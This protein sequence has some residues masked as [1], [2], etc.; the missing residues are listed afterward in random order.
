MFAASRGQVVPSCYPHPHCTPFPPHE[1]V[2]MAAVE[3][4]GDPQALSVAVVYVVIAICHCCCHS[5]YYPPHEQLL[6]KLGVGG[7]LS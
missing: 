4:A 3:G 1:Q 2:L 5:T 7:V 6:V